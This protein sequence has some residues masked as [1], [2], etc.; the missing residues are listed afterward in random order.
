MLEIMEK[1]P[2]TAVVILNWNGFKDT[3]ECLRSLEKTD[4][5]NFRI[6]LVDN[7][8]ENGEGGELEKKFP[9][10]HLISNAVNRGFAGGNNDGMN[11]AVENGFE[12]VVNLNNDCVVTVD[13]LRNLIETIVSEKADFGSPRIM[14]YPETD[15]ICSAG[16]A[17]LPDGSSLALE[18]GAPYAGHAVARRLFSACGA[19]SAYSVKCLKE[20]KVKGTQ[21]FDELYFAYLEDLDLGIRANAKGFKGVYAPRSVVYHKHSAT[22]GRHSAFKLF[23]S[24]KNRILNELLNYPLYFVPMGE[25][26]SIIKYA[27]KIAGG[28]ISRIQKSGPPGAGYMKELGLARTAACFLKAKWWIIRHLGEI[29]PDRAERKKKGMVNNAVLKDF[30]WKIWKR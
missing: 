14:F 29:L 27:L 3:V 16:D 5:G 7:G 25:I 4:Y 17:L 20:L 12:Y 30:Y 11:W 22:A 8:S 13:W 18:R 2:K 24:E 10:V 21:Y 9:G 23:N 6:V 26:L 1:E 15:R 28:V 19:A